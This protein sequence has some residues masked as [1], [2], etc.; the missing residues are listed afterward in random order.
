MNIGTFLFSAV[1]IYLLIALIMYMTKSH[2]SPYEVTEGTIVEDSVYTGI[3][4]RSETEVTASKDGYLNYYLDD[5]SK[6]GAGQHVC[7]MSKDSLKELSAAGKSKSVKKLSSAQ[8][9]VMLTGIQ[10]YVTSYSPD[11]YAS[12]YDLHN[13][14][15]AAYGVN[16][17]DYMAD[18]ID[19]LSRDGV[20]I[21]YI[22][23]PS[24]GLIVYSVDSLDGLTVDGI[25]S[26]LFDKNDYH[27]QINRQ[28]A[29]LKKGDSAFKIIQDE[30]W[31]IV[32]P[33]DDQTADKM[34]DIK[35]IETRIGNMQS[36]IW[37]D[38]SILK[39]DHDLFGHL[40]YSADMLQ[41]ASQRYV[42]VELILHNDTGLKIPASAVTSRKVYEIPS[43]FVIT[44]PNTAVTGV[45][46]REEGGKQSFKQVNVFTELEKESADKK[47]TLQRYYYLKKS[48]LPENTVICKDGDSKTYTVDK[49]VNMKGVFNIN[50]GYASFQYIHVIASNDMYYI[51]ENNTIYG[52]ATYDHIALNADK[53][54]ENIV[55]H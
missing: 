37:G 55:V 29:H 26:D 7:A 53:L 3:I 45:L 31:H 9:S 8:E 46:V 2:V 38:F 51:V 28:N 40:T 30:T 36:T 22:D 33:L 5:T 11:Q 19:E 54:K 4:V 49:T 17:A 43:E 1:L 12:I 50:K 52:P 20:D 13:D 39:Q 24:D 18:Q 25:T 48:E 15:N 35:M 47:D 10:H 23:A 21:D 44:D 27:A 14:I 6:A 41:F 34:K 16:S 42:N 32:F